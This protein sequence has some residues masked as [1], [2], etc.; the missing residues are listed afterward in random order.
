VQVSQSNN[1]SEHKTHFP[2]SSTYLSAH[3]QT[4]V[5]GLGSG[6]QLLVS[7]HDKQLALSL[8]VLHPGNAVLQATQV[9]F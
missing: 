2:L 7:S 1:L 3:S 6:F 8:Q 4:R 9:S 5:F